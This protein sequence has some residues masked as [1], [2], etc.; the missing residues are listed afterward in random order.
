[1]LN[2]PFKGAYANLDELLKLRYRRLRFRSSEQGETTHTSGIRLSRMRGRGVDFSEVRLYQPGDD[3]RNI[4]WRVTARKAKP[5]TKVFREERE[6]PVFLL[7]DQSQTMFF[8]SQDRLKSVAAAE[9]TGLLAWQALHKGDRVGGMILSNEHAYPLKPY[10]NTRSVIRLLTRLAD[11]NQ[12]LSRI[13]PEHRLK[14]D[15]ALLQL[16]KL[17]H[18][19]HRIY[20]ISDFT[21]PPESWRKHIHRLTRHNDVVLV[22]VSDPLEEEL[23]PADLYSIT[24]GRQR[25]QLSTAND[26]VRCQYHARFIQHQEEVSGLA[27]GAGATFLPLSTT[28]DAENTLRSKIRYL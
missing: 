2:Q 8:G 23:P 22:M 17:A 12:Q 18:T 5:H 20:I 6:R 28:D 9:L 24:D 19:G 13:P 25:L 27:A 1:M 4:D 3:V 16:V 21:T 26:T 14:I 15:T 7:T 11:C 10:R